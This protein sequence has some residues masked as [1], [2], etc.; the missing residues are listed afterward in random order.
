[1]PWCLSSARRHIPSANLS[2]PVPHPE[3][4][5]V[6]FLCSENEKACSGDDLQWTPTFSTSSTASSHPAARSHLHYLF[7]GTAELVPTL[8]LCSCCS[9]CRRGT[10]MVFQA[11]LRLEGITIINL[12]CFFPL[13]LYLFSC[14]LVCLLDECWYV[15]G[16]SDLEVI[17]FVE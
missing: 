6:H 10:S 1:M 9:R 17:M 3:P 5:L 16:T 14:F 4:P 15:V 11:L 8:D 13:A 2:T 12:P 7:A